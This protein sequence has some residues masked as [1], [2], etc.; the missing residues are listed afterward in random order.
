MTNGQAIV[1]AF[2]STLT[3]W[4]LSE[5]FNF[6]ADEIEEWLKNKIVQRKT[7]ETNTHE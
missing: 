6:I 1:L 3:I 2:I 5:L 7:K 4:G